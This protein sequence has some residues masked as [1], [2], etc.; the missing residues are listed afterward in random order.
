MDKIERNRRTL[1]L[2]GLLEAIG[3]M[4]APRLK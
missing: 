1:G 4:G 3:L 2:L